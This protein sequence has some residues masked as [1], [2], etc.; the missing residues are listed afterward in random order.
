MLK[1]CQRELEHTVGC[2]YMYYYSHMHVHGRQLYSVIH[3]LQIQQLQTSQNLLKQQK[4]KS[5]EI[6]LNFKIQSERLV[7]QYQSKLHQ[8][9][10]S[11]KEAKA[12]IQEFTTF[13]MVL[14]SVWYHTF[15]QCLILIQDLAGKLFYHLHREKFSESQ[16]DSTD[17]SHISAKVREI[18]RDTLMLSEGELDDFFKEEPSEHVSKFI[19]IHKH[20]NDYFIAIIQTAMEDPR[21]FTNLVMSTAKSKVRMHP[22]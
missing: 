17:N 2:Q 18:A 9:E 10:C 14:T 15:L 11:L 21:Q 22:T 19:I 13:T 12:V 20:N 7:K 3:K 8:A 5:D 16:H 1:K 6:E 4:R